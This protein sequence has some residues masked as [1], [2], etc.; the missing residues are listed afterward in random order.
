MIINHKGG[1]YKMATREEVK[2]TELEQ[3]ELDQLNEIEENLSNKKDKEV[4]LLAYELD[5]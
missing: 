2:F 5:E 4:V 1:V 3:D